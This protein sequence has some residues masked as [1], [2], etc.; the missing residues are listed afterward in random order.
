MDIRLPSD[1]REAIDEAPGAWRSASPRWR[2]IG[3]I[4]AAILAVV[5][6]RYLL[7]PHSAQQVSEPPAPV[8][9]AVA[10][11]QTVIVLEH[12][13]G[14][15][16]ANA[17]VQVTSRVEGQLVAARFKEGDIVHKGDLLFQLDPRPF[18]AALA[19]TVAAE[20][21]DQAQLTS[22]RNDAAR[23]ASLA[24][25]GAAS[26]SQA[27]QFVAAAK[28]L[29]A[30]IAAD[31]AMVEAARLNVTYTQIRSPIDGKTGPILIQ[32]GN[33]VPA[34]G[35]NPLVVITQIQPVKVS[36]FLPQSDLPR[37]QDQMRSHRLN[38]TLAAHDSANTRLTAPVDFVGNEVDNTT[39]TVELRATFDNRD[40][41]LVPGQ[42]LDVSVSLAEL[43]N[44]IVVPREAV[45]QGPQG[46]FIYVAGKDNKAEMRPVTVLNDDGRID[47]VSGDIRAGDRVITDGQLRV[48]AGKP[49]AIARSR[50]GAPQ[51]DAR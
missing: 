19:Q 16:V 35:T 10:R 27:D 11:T 33:M 37:I 44:A 20:N 12:T 38:A 43:P 29:A 40:Y 28:A 21:R 24:A 51:P 36:F 48:V 32:P 31:R 5:L 17:T 4:V 30:T 47:A 46:R 8:R 41:R 6:A 3:G 9:V 18:Q 15:I 26:K 25:Q 50:G 23:Y 34:S 45:N 22:A 42:L 14:T 1:Q 2:L 49:I 39:G 13:I 7:S